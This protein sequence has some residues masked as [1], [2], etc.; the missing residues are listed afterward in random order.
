MRVG[1][2]FDQDQACVRVG[3][4]RRESIEIRSRIDPAELE[5]RG[6]SSTSRKKPKRAAVHSCSTRRHVLTGLGACD[7]IVEMAAMPEAKA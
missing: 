5:A 1:G 2:G 7:A 4:R 6:V 3:H